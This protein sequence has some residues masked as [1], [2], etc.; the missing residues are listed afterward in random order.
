MLPSAPSRKQ[1]PRVHWL[2]FLLA[3][4]PELPVADVFRAFRDTQRLLVGSVSGEWPSALSLLGDMI[5][6]RFC[7]TISFNSAAAA[8]DIG[9]SR[10]CRM[11]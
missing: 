9:S 2:S 10:S 8:I 11:D 7:D 5:A 6:R 4:W 3:G 1:V